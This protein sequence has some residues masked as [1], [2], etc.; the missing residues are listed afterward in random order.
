MKTKTVK[1]YLFLTLIA[2][3]CAAC[4]AV[5]CLFMGGGTPSVGAATQEHDDAFGYNHS[6]PAGSESTPQE[7]PKAGGKL[8][9]GAYYLTD[10]ITLAAD[11][12]IPADAT[13]DLCLN[14]YKLIGTGN[15][16][17]ITVEKNAI[18]N[19]HDCNS[20]N[21]SHGY[22]V[23]EHGKYE[24]EG[25]VTGT[26]PG[27]VITGG[28]G[29][30]DGNNTYGGGISLDGTGAVFNMYGGTIAGNMA[31][32]DL[33]DYSKK[34]ATYGGGVYIAFDDDLMMGGTFNM[35]G[36][37]IEGNTAGSS[38]QV[39]GQEQNDLNNDHDRGGGVAVN[40]GTFNMYGGAIKNNA[41][42]DGAGVYASGNSSFTMYGDIANTQG[43]G[44]YS[45][46]ISGNYAR[47]NGGG[48][49]LNE[50]T[51]Q[52]GGTV[53]G[54]AYEG[55]SIA[56]NTALSF[57]GGAYVNRSDTSELLIAN[58]SVTGNTAMTGGGIYVHSG[59]DSAGSLVLG[60]GEG[61][62]V[63]IT[64]NSAIYYD[65]R[66]TENMNG[67]GGGVFMRRADSYNFNE[68][69]LEE[70]QYESNIDMN[71]VI[72]IT[73]NTSKPDGRDNA[74][75]DNLYLEDGISINEHSTK[76]N[77]DGSA[78][79]DNII[80][81][82][83]KIGISLA[84]REDVYNNKETGGEITGTATVGNYYSEDTFIVYGFDKNV[85][86]DDLKKIFSS[87]VGGEL[88][89]VIADGSGDETKGTIT[90]GSFI[91]KIPYDVATGRAHNEYSVEITATDPTR[92]ETAENINY[93][94]I[95]STG[96]ESARNITFT[97][98]VPEV[99]DYL[100][101]T[102]CGGE[103]RNGTSATYSFNTTTAA[104]AGSIFGEYTTDSTTLSVTIPYSDYYDAYVASEKAEYGIHIAY[105]GAEA[106]VAIDGDITYYYTIEQAF[107]AAGDLSTSKDS[108][109]KITMLKNA[110]TEDTLTVSDSDYVTLD[111]NGYM[112]RYAGGENNS[113]LTLNKANF[114]LKDGYV[115]SGNEAPDPER[116]HYYSTDGT[117]LFVFDEYATSGN[118][119]IGG[120]ITGGTGTIG[121]IGTRGGAIY[122]NETNI[123]IESGT[124]AGNSATYAGGG[125]Y[126]Y[127]G[128]FKMSGGKI[129]GNIA[130]YTGDNN[131]IGSEGG[132][133]F[134]FSPKTNNEVTEDFVIEAKAEISYNVANMGGGVYMERASA[135]DAATNLFY[136]KGGS[137]SYNKAVERTDPNAN[138]NYIYAFGGGIY[139]SVALKIT[140]GA[141][142][143]NE[144]EQLGGGIYSVNSKSILTMEGNAIVS[145][146]EAK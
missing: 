52:I 129:S 60:G 39:A 5:G 1:K 67:Y 15:G 90:T 92:A 23:N 96:A 54:T 125:L 4:V 84:A 78:D 110:V 11:I 24:F 53:G 130:I 88:K 56:G 72:N 107:T 59:S 48:V 134:I 143:Y 51:A 123:N 13:V 120:V 12:I 43:E 81:L 61:T 128:T 138:K 91:Y 112:L 114:T 57:G 70:G 119:I 44:T 109:A 21:G 85:D 141:I 99:D 34:D 22:K 37:T 98:T 80:Y 89:A 31:K 95:S 73:N 113:V 137:I 7:L 26:I 17:V 66:P 122:A 2:V 38:D 65:S 58:G 83:S 82:G 33:D 18:F 76:G 135:A 45:P 140:G 108:P 136:I 75:A 25:T 40:G 68:D 102:L 131:L 20:T 139:S 35:Y 142:T 63:T 105:I 97:V 111:L 117:G 121:N 93:L 100:V 69:K 62:A 115:V 116:V 42:D 3:L 10:N 103:Y 145:H 19:L 146:N 71:G 28:T 30:V 27:G 55:G 64:G 9:G 74:A 32:R 94:T 46:V 101:I 49:Y 77:V 126:I 50:G 127:A 8:S 144:S 133:L 106:S 118:N 79:T 124:I 36:G 16:P 132:G 29:K 6:G 87:D 47:H 86:V 104:S 14:G 41:A